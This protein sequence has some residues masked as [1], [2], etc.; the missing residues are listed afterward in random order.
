MGEDIGRRRFIKCA[1]GSTVALASMQVFGTAA[2]HAR[3]CKY[4]NVAQ[5][6]T[7]NAIA[8]QIV[9]ADDSPGAHEAGILFYIDGLLNGRYG[10][11]Y[12]ERYE[13]GLKLI[14]RFSRGQFHKDFVNLNSDQQISV[15]KALE[16]GSAAGSEGSRFFVLILQHTIEGY[17]GDPEH[18]GNPGNASWR[19]I[20]FEG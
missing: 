20:G 10:G 13:S 11:F 7:V 4:F 17:Y 2:D 5:A 16:S 1:A 18:H 12:R 19:M 9:P 3:G 6:A 15:L 14:D 8:E